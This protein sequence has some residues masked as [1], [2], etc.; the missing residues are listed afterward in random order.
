MRIQKYIDHTLLKPDVV[1]K[2]IIDLCRE[3]LEYGFAAVCINP[4]YTS[5]VR[6]EL[7]GSDVK[8][9]VAI[10]FPLGAASTEVKAYEAIEAAANGAR[11]M[12]MVINIG[13]LKDRKYEVVE[14]DIAAVVNAVEGKAMVKAIIE[15]CLLTPDEMRKACEIAVKAG[16][17]FVK[18]STGFSTGGAKVEDVRL[19]R[20]TV[21]ARVGVKASGGIR[22]YKTALEMINAG[23]TRIGTSAGIEIVKGC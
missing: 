16:A 22:D 21:G 18:T 20:D 6:R 10:G 13:A 3:A 8:T 19:M 7:E 15:C 1:E 17:A 14:R 4:F 11:E 5:L 23:A 9:C 2:Q 12:D